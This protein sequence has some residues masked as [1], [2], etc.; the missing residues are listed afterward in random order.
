MKQSQ[1]QQNYA[2]FEDV[3]QLCKTLYSSKKNES[4]IEYLGK[5][6]LTMYSVSPL[7]HLVPLSEL[8]SLERI[9]EPSPEMMSAF[10]K[11]RILLS[12]DDLA[13]LTGLTIEKALE[14]MTK[15]SISFSRELN[16]IKPTCSL[17]DLEAFLEETRWNFGKEI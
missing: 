13:L 2:P 10:M 7:I 8:S 17:F 12:V 1:I 14:L 3:P 9:P 5:L 11:H 16:P 6:K 15:V 4:C